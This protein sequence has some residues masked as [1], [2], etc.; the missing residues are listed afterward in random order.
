M[1]LL[2]LELMARVI[3]HELLEEKAHGHLDCGERILEVVR[4]DGHHLL[5]CASGLLGGLEEERAV[6]REGYSP[7]HFFRDRDITIGVS[8]DGGARG[9]GGEGARA[10]GAPPPPAEW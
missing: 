1:K 6:N 9:G 7:P 3:W 8:A 4:H 10:T 5:A 2:A